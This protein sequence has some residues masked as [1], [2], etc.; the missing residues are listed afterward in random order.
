MPVLRRASIVL[1]LTAA[2]SL[3]LAGCAGGAAS[4]GAGAQDGAIQV[5][6]STNVYGHLAEQVGGDLV[7]V[8]SIVSSESQD[9]HSFEPS[10]RDQLTVASA[11]LIIENGGGYDAFI[12]ALIEASGSDARIVTAVEFSDAWPENA[13][14]DDDAHDEAAVGDDHSHEHVDGFNE[15]VWYDPHAIGGVVEQIAAELGELSPDD[16][17]AFSAN[18]DELLAGIEVLEASL[19][20]IATTHDGDRVFATEPL[21]TYLINDAGLEN[22]TPAAFSE[23][24]EEGQDVPAATMLE[25]L[26]LLRDGGV[27][28]VIA[29]AQ[30]GGAETT[31]LLD[32]ASDAGIPVVE[33]TET[34]PGDQTYISWMQQNIDA[35][36]EALGS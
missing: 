35:L 11:D 22:V 30:T 16:A 10:A 32:E 17:D 27:T 36:A 25:A 9:P 29:N 21:A 13:R 14:H 24:V 33:Y 2:A 20:D 8:T 7:D 4:P 12:D 26:T 31:Q 19:A 28:A 5:V 23:A 34:L 18:A 3:A 6:A 15:H 1:G